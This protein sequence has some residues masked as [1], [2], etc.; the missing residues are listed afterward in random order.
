MS[1]S[2]RSYW[3]ALLIGVAIGVLVGVAVVLGRPDLAQWELSPS[4]ARLWEVV[5]KAIAGYL[6]IIGAIIT[7]FKYIDE[8]TEHRENAQRELRRAFLEQRQTV[9]RRLGLSLAN[10]L[11]YDP[12]DDE[13]EPAKQEF[14]RIYWGEIPLV[15][16]EGVAKALEPFSDTLYSATREDK[17]QLA[18]LSTVI[19]EACRVSLGETWGN[20]QKPA[21]R[22][23]TNRE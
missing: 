18:E 23:E 11:N 5:L 20:G 17:K 15:S 21:P 6:A 2:K 19:S 8:R 14:Y 1:D 16:D 13:W 12:G 3:I 10:I 4:Q 9:Y 22:E 7:A